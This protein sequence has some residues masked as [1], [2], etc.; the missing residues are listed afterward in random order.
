MKPYISFLLPIRKRPYSLKRS[1]DSLYTTCSDPTSYEVVII[2]DSDDIETINEFNSWEKKFNYKVEIMDRL[3]YDY[4]NE[5]YNKACSLSSGEWLWVWNDDTCMLEKNW[6]LIIKEYDKKFLIINPYNT[7]DVDREYIKTHTLFPI[8][9]KKY[10]ELLSHLSPWNH[11]DTYTERVID[12][13]NLLKNE[14]RIIH[15]HEKNNDEVSKEITYHRIS[16]PEEQLS[17]DRDKII[18]Y[19]NNNE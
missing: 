15:T 19:L 2:F 14:F 4:L 1:L 7:R 5:Y 9:P 6:D 10:Y 8:V 18:K 12:G 17:I 13:L 16:I 11:I 3:G